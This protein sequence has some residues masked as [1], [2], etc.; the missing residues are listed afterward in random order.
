[1]NTKEPVKTYRKNGKRNGE[2][3]EIYI[4]ALNNG[5]VFA[6][7]VITR[8]MGFMTRCIGNISGNSFSTEKQA[9]AGAV[10][11]IRRRIETE[12]SY[13]GEPKQVIE[14]LLSDISQIQFDFGNE[15]PKDAA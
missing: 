3:C 2:Y 13:K 11:Y 12:T 6:V 1:M 5:Y 10:Q 9:L 15:P 14:K 7:S 8:T 4:Y